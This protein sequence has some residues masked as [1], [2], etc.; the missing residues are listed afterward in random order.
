MSQPHLKE[1]EYAREEDY[2]PMPELIKI[3]IFEHLTAS[4][5]MCAQKRVRGADCAP[6]TRCCLKG[7]AGM[8]KS[9][10]MQLAHLPRG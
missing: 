10:T 3:I 5:Q 9:I 2:Y 4:S 1:S 8:G 7:D 6:Q